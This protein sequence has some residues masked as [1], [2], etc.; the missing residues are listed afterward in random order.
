MGSPA[1]F[2]V[3]STHFNN[4]KVFNSSSKYF[5]SVHNNNPLGS[6]SPRLTNI[7]KLSSGFL[8]PGICKALK[9]WR[10]AKSVGLD[11]IASFFPRLH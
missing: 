9:I 8:T 11:G 2:Q 4:Y 7:T 3:G 1:Q 10:P 5:L 6:C